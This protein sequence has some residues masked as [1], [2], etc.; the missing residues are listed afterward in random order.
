MDLA[1]RVTRLEEN[2]K[3]VEKLKAYQQTQDKTLKN[4]SDSL[5]LLGKDNEDLKRVT[6]R[7]IIYLAIASDNQDLITTFI[8]MWKRIANPAIIHEI[9]QEVIRILSRE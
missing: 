2:L 6:L 4:L 8:K 1:E 5:N 9:R 7:S 3:E